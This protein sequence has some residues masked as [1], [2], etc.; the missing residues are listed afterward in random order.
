MSKLYKI[1]DDY[2]QENIIICNSS[3]LVDVANEYI[4]AEDSD[5]LI[6]FED[7]KSAT[8]FLKSLEINIEEIKGNYIEINRG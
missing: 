7:V 3:G 2:F 8:E 6:K 1:T 5:S 4:K